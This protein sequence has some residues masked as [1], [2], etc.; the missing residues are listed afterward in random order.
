M[1][2]NKIIIRL[3]ASY[4]T[5]FLTFF[6]APSFA[7]DL[8][9]KTISEVE[10]FVESQMRTF[11]GL[12][13]GREQIMESCL[14]PVDNPEE[15]PEITRLQKKVD[16]EKALFFERNSSNAEKIQLYNEQSKE[17]ENENCNIFQALVNNASSPTQCGNAKKKN[18]LVIKIGNSL[19]EWKNTRIGIFDEFS[20]IATLEAKS[21]VSEG[22]TNSLKSRYDNF[23]NQAGNKDEEFFTKII[24]SL[25]VFFNSEGR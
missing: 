23:N 4:I 2:F 12:S 13:A 21:C 6:L 17:L 7:S 14:N 24:Q 15:S 16:L 3:V 8:G 1:N 5:F 18:N 9:E 20:K 22:F 19:N 11:Q 25:A 10:F